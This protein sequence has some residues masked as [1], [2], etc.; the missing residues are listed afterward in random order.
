MTAAA[1]I[2]SRTY[3]KLRSGSQ[4]RV[5]YGQGQ[6]F[7]SPYFSA[8]FLATETREARLGITV[9][10]K[11]GKAVLRNLCKRRLRALFQQ[12]HAEVIH[13]AGYDLVVNAKTELATAPY[14]LVESAFLQTLRRFQTLLQKRATLISSSGTL[15]QEGQDES[16]L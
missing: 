7:H 5:V 10:R 3:S 4:F 14:A 11:V 15:Q 6:R 1:F 13:G 8:F 9:T 2:V 16:K 12:H